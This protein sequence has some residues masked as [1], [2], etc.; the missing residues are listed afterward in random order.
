MV[1]F[2]SININKDIQNYE[3]YC[4][5]SIEKAQSQV[6]KNQIYSLESL[7]AS[8][9]LAI[10]LESDSSYGQKL[11]KELIKVVLILNKFIFFNFQK[12]NVKI[13]LLQ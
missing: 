10:H 8:L 7:Y 4:M 3:T 11:I 6:T 9:L 1:T 12:P 13:S 2:Y 5:Q